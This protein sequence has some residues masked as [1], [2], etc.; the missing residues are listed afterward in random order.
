MADLMEQ[1]SSKLPLYVRCIKPNDN[2]SSREFNAKRVEH[3][4]NQI[5]K[6][7]LKTYLKM[8]INTFLNFL[9]YKRNLG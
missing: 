6:L 5:V 8:S 7:S 1:L 2:K 9:K 3:Q 4:V